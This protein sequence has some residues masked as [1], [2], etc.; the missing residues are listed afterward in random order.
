MTQ[1]SESDTTIYQNVLNKINEC[2]MEVE[3]PEINDPD[4]ILKEVRSIKMIN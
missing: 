1:T 2:P 4:I 3:I